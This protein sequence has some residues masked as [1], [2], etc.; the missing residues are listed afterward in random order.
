METWGIESKYVI[1]NF[2]FI[3]SEWSHRQNWYGTEPNF[4]TFKEDYIRLY[5]DTILKVVKEEDSPRVIES[6]SPS[7]GQ[8]T[9]SEGWIPDDPQDPLYGDIHHYDYKNDNWGALQ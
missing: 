8:L 7:N 6:T 1:K 4:D 2:A 3:I 9:E 5:V